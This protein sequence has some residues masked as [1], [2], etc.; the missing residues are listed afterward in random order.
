MYDPSTKKQSLYILMPLDMVKLIKKFQGFNVNDPS[1][2]DSFEAC[3]QN[4]AEKLRSLHSENEHGKNITREDL[5]RLHELFLSIPDIACM[6]SLLNGAKR[7]YPEAAN[8]PPL[9]L[10]DALIA[11]YNKLVPREMPELLITSGLR[12]K[13]D[14]MLYKLF[15][16][17][18][19]DPAYV[20]VPSQSTLSF[21]DALL[22]LKLSHHPSFVSVLGH[23]A[24]HS[25]NKVLG[26]SVMS[27]APQYSQR[28]FTSLAKG[29]NIQDL[30]YMQ[31]VF[32]E[33]GSDEL[34][35]HLN[36]IVELH[37]RNHAHYTSLHLGNIRSNYS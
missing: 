22:L 13:R 26:S 3:Y 9:R 36:Q 7:I 31:E 19:L 33:S 2:H 27:R 34:L 29:V 8:M 30:H 11:H 28:L 14:W 23:L 20:A 15:T 6:R 25:L 24:L 35:A 10:L 18:Y 4:L 5:F 12:M 32:L 21:E 1:A 16:K 17:Y 37:L